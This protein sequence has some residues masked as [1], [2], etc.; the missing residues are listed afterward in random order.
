MRSSPVPVFEMLCRPLSL[1]NLLCVAIIRKVDTN[2]LIIIKAQLTGFILYPSIPLDLISM[3]R[4]R[5]SHYL[6]K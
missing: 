5:V 2:P 6:T 4:F 3:K 1:I